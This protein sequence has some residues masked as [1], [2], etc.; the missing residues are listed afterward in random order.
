[1]DVFLYMKI[2]I[3]M[4]TDIMGI[5]ILMIIGMK[6]V[7]SYLIRVDNKIA[8]FVLVCPHCNYIE[9]VDT[10]CIGEFFIL[11]K[12]R[13]LGVGR[14]VAKKIFDLHKGQWEVCYLTTNKPAR[15]FWRKVIREYTDGDFTEHGNE[16]NTFQGFLFRNK[17]NLQ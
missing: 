4:N 17:K 1:M 16:M 8:G 15:S 13:K 11:M 9:G 2:W 6:R 7:G 3:L 5:Y 10:R 14:F 12:F